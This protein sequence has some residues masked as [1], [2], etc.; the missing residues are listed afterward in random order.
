VVIGVTRFFY[1][2]LQR[3]PSARHVQDQQPKG[4]I[5]EDHRRPYGSLKGKPPT[6]RISNVRGVDPEREPQ[7][8]TL[9]LKEA[10]SRFAGD[11][12]AR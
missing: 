6:S 3:D 4:L 12:A 1:V 9:I 11:Q 5:A 2:W 7:V 10:M 8:I